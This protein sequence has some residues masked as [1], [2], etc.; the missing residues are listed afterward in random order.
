MESRQ[1][2][3]EPNGTKLG[4]A[5]EVTQFGVHAT[6]SYS[7]ETTGT[8]GAGPPRISRGMELP[9]VFNSRFI[10]RHVLWTPSE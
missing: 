1:S 2:G 8:E 7:I 6:F 3:A 10:I 4:R 9:G 5:S